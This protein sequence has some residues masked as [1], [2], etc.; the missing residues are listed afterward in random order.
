MPGRV[1]LWKKM[2]YLA[3][4]VLLLLV[5]FAVP[6]VLS[7]YFSFT[8]MALTGSDAGSLA[9]RGLENYRRMFSDLVIKSAVINTLVFVVGSIVGQTLLGFSFAYLMRSCTRW[10]RKLVGGVIMLGWVMPEMVAAYC[11]SSLFHDSGTLNLILEALGI[12]K[13]SWLYAWPM[14]AVIVANIWRGTAFSMVAYQAALDDVPAEIEESSQLDGAGVFRRIY[15]IIL[16]TIKGTIM[17][18]T[19]LITLMTLGSFGLIWIMTGGG[20]GGKTQTLPILMYIKAFK[21]SQL[22]Y[23]VAI[24]ILSLVIGVVF[25]V[26]YV[27]AAGREE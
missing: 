27:K 6:V 12:E 13:V 3:P 11:M 7:V 4:S 1:P 25:G 15:Y 17:T 21:N 16:P 2:S 24:S 18:N 23:G 9:F 8:N 10:V 5:F 22:G 14:G 20:P 26:I 19:M